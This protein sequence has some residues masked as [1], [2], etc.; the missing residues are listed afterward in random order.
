M[1]TLLLSQVTFGQTI[2]NTMSYKH[3]NNDKYFRLNYENDFFS[4]T[5][6]YYTQGIHVELVSPAMKHFPLTK[7]LPH[8]KYS[9]TKY[10]NNYCK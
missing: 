1:I 5:D 3:I 6:M 9:I 7:V 2:N 4:G 8:P 10:G